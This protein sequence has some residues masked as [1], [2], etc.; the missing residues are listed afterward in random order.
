[1][2]AIEKPEQDTDPV[3]ESYL[4]PASTWAV[5]ECRGKIPDSIVASEMYAFTQWLPGSEFVHAHAPEM[6]VY[7]EGS[8]DENY[9]SEFWL[10]ITRKS[11]DKAG[12]SAS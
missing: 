3:L 9:Y 5:F 2:I 12:S 10:P 11:K 7:L 1:M 8:N 6:E 4:V